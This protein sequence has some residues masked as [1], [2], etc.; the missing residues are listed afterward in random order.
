MKVPIFGGFPVQNPTK[1]ANRLKAL[2]RGI[3]AHCILLLP[4]VAFCG[5]RHTSSTLARVLRDKKEARPEHSCA[6]RSAIVPQFL[7]HSKAGSD[8]TVFVLHSI[9]ALC[10]CIFSM[11]FLLILCRISLLLI[12]VSPP[13]LKYLS[14]FMFHHII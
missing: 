5:T 6:S 4:Y 12:H 2:S 7:W 1:K 10:V 9:W 3:S 11:G 14:Q 13:L 8:E